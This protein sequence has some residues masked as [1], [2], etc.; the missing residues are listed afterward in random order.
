MPVPND[1]YLSLSGG[2]LLYGIHLDDDAL[3]L[4]ER[5]TDLLFLW[6]RSMNLVSRRDMERF[7]EYHLLDSLKISACVDMVSVENMMDFGSGPGLPGIPLKIAFPHLQMV[8]VDSM[9]KRVNFLTQVISELSFSPVSVIRS[10][11]EEMPSSFNGAFDMVITRA[12]VSLL[13]GF[14]CTARFLRPKGMLVSIKGEHIENELLELQN[15]LDT[16][17]F[18]IAIFKPPVVDKVRTGYIVIITKR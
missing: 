12:T 2:A 7:V 17:L 15:Y 16:R 6:N 18:N 8:L 13:R 10:R 3:S 5:Y 11:V 14:F 1:F 9:A 4:F